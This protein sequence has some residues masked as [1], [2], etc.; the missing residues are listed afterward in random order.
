MTDYM[1]RMG[2]Y[3]GDKSNS[4]NRHRT[5]DASFTALAEKSSIAQADGTSHFDVPHLPDLDDEAS[6]CINDATTLTNVPNETIGTPIL[7]YLIKRY[8]RVQA[9]MQQFYDKRWANYYPLQRRCLYTRTYG[10]V[11]LL[12]PY[13]AITCFGLL[14]SFHPLFRSGFSSGHIARVPLFV[15]LLTANRNSWITMLLGIPFE[16]GLFYHKLSGYLSFSLGVTHAFAVY[17]E[18]NND[19]KSMHF[20]FVGVINSSGTYLELF[21]FLIGLSSLPYVRR[22]LFEIF[23]FLHIL[24]ALGCLG[25][26][27]CHSGLSLFLFGLILISSDLFFRMIY[28]AGIK[29]P[30]TASVRPISDSVIEISFPKTESFDYNPGQ[31]IFLLVPEISMFQVGACNF[32]FSFISAQLICLF[33]CLFVG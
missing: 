21:I 8:P 5:S 24:F 13:V 4:I 22:R 11:L 14:T 29:Y 27:F 16:R 25:C 20:L 7:H 9:F 23:Y 12:V 28:M 18:Q 30:K 3:S 2:W 26:A 1:A 19:S 32:S 6:T 17:A 33:V 15:V 10:E 31:Y